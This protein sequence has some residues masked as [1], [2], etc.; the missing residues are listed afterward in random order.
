MT[1][2]GIVLF[3]AIIAFL[4]FLVKT[5]RQGNEKKR[6]F[7]SYLESKGDYHNLIKFG[8]YNSNGIKESRSIPFVYKRIY[9]AYEY[10]K[11]EMFLEYLTYIKQN[12]QKI[13]LL[14]FLTY[15]FFCCLMTIISG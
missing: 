13:M 14:V 6:K 7:I 10:N 15:F 2:A 8:F 1:V 12:S 9:E 11:D 5:I 4:I 3:I